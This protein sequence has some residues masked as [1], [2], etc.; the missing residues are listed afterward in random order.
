MIVGLLL[1]KI[2]QLSRSNQERHK[3]TVLQMRKNQSTKSIKFKKKKYDTSLRSSC[4]RLSIYCFAFGC[5]F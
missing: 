2:N 4:T 3:T 1:K 5:L